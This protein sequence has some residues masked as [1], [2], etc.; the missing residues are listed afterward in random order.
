MDFGD[1]FNDDAH[2][3]DSFPGQKVAIGGE[4]DFVKLAFDPS[5]SAKISATRYVPKKLPNPVA[6][7]LKFTPTQVAAV[8]SCL[9]PGLSL[10][11]GPPGTGKT[12]VATHVISCLHRTYPTQR[13]VVIAHSNA[14]LNDLFEKISARGYVDERYMIRLGSGERD[15]NVESTHDFSKRG[16]VNY[17]LAKREQQLKVV[18]ELSE[19]LGVSTAAERGPNGESR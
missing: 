13:I 4:G 8:K 9:H 5:D 1:A 10:I 7:P 6:T 2:L 11:V 12:D 18:Q 17:T 14:A 19:S 16:R 15:L 3:R